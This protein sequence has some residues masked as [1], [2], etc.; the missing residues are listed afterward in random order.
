M[1]NKSKI[2]KAALGLLAGAVMFA[3]VTVSA[4]TQSQAQALVASL[5]ITGASATALVTALTTTSSTGTMMTS[6]SCFSFQ[7]NL[8][9]GATSPDVM[10][11]QKV[12]NSDPDTALA[13]AAGTTGSTGNEGTHFGPATKAA[14]IKFQTKH[15]ISPLSGYVG[16]LTRAALNA[17]CTTTSTTTGGTTT[18]GTTTGGT[19]TTT[20]T[21]GPVS[22]MLGSDTPVAGTIIAGQA[23]ADLAHFTVSGSGTLSSVTLQRTGISDQNTLTN[24]Y[25]YNGNVRLTD[26]YSFNTAGSLTMSN[27]NIAVNGTMTLS[28]KGDVSLATTSY[29]IG[30]TMTSYMTTGGAATT[31]NLVGNQMFI[32]TGEQSLPSATIQS[33]TVAVSSSPSVNP[34]TTGYTLW[35]APVQINTRSLWLKAVNFRVIGSAPSNALT[36]ITLYKDGVAVPGNATITTINGSEYAVFDYSANPLELTTGTHTIDFRADISNGS[37]RTIQISI[38]Q[39]ADLVLYDQQT[40][41]NVAAMGI[42]NTTAYSISIAQ[43]SLTASID[44]TF[45]TLTNVTGGAS[46][47]AIAR[48]TLHAYGEDMKVNTL[49]IL[50]HVTGTTPAQVSCVTGAACG[51]ENVTVYFNG[52]SI[53]SQTSAWVDGS[54]I[55]LTPGAQMIVPAGQDSTLEI[56]ADLRNMAGT[57]YTLGAVS[58]D[59]VMGNGTAQGMS[60][61][62]S[63]NVPGVS[64]NTLTMQT[65]QLVVGNNTNYGNQTM[66]SNTQNVKIGSFTLQNNST[67]ESIHVTSLRVNTAF[68]TPTFTSGTV[69]TGSQAI[70]VS[71]TVGFTASSTGVLGDTIVIPGATPATGIVTAINSATQLQVNITSGG[72]TPTVGG[73]ITDSSKTA[74]GIAYIQS[75]RTSESSGNGSQAI[76]PTGSDTFSV[77]F[78]L[79][80]GASK[81]IDIMANIGAANFGTVRTNLAVQ[82]LGATSNV[83]V[84][85]NGDATL[86]LVPVYGQTITMANG[87]VNVPTMVSSDS[88]QAQYI[89]SSSGSANGTTVNYKFIAQNGAGTVNTLKFTT[90]GPVTQISVNGQTCNAVAGSCN[91]VGVNLAVPNTTTGV[92]VPAYVSYGTVSSVG[93]IALSGATSSI[94]MNEYDYTMGSGA[95]TL[96]TT[97]LGSTISPVMYLVGAKPSLAVTTTS[98]AGLSTGENHLLDVAVTPV[99]GTIGV[100]EMIFSVSSSQTTGTS[101][102][103]AVRLADSSGTTITAFSC[104]SYSGANL[105]TSSTLM[106]SGLFVKCID[107][108]DSNGYQLSAAKTFSLYGTVSFAAGLGAAG[109]SA[110]TTNLTSLTQG[111]LLVSPFTWYDVSGG[112]AAAQTLAQDAANFYSYPTQT[113]SVH[114]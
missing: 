67:S 4:M 37:A 55:V 62:N 105:A 46:N 77:D 10:Q 18:G 27:L 9:L 26:G 40:G 89:S 81:V 56:R 75:L 93:G 72:V 48:F 25:L 111:G 71:S 104:S 50:P 5:G 103:S 23:T 49:T 94:V 6:G 87:S 90:T 45:Q 35:S 79:P 84:Y 21:T 19:T 41:T 2:A 66:N 11:L 98:N 33:N 68:A 101:T 91:I 110:V 109:T 38:Q 61:Q 1:T 34:G 51:L 28:V 57:N 80:A 88:T 97:G 32:A 74:T 78:V 31:V 17:M 39:A 44:P 83:S 8:T 112:A 82:G 47:M 29:S 30:V 36:N 73:M 92:E 52:S 65:G 102:L 60:S 24:L 3:G 70:N 43:G 59:L 22:V 96:V 20:T 95:Q 69:T 100:G 7:N 114:N 13:V 54:N 64:G 63:L 15:S 12:L 106:S 86:G 113:W 58:A 14:V 107:T 108:G 53:G 42:P 16:P 76:A 99:G 85:E